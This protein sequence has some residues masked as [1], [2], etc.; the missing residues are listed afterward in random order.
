MEEWR[1]IPGYEG[2]YQASDLGQVRSLDRVEQT[3]D[4]PRR[5]RGR[6]LHPGRRRASGHVAVC[7]GKR[8]TKDVHPLVLRAFVGPPPEGHEALHLN[9]TP[10]DN[11][12]NNLRWGTRGENIAMD[13][14]VKTRVP[15]RGERAP[16]AVLTE[17]MVREARVLRAAGVPYSKLE[18]MLGV[19]LKTISGAVHRRTWGHVA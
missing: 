1:D 4:G 12:L 19:D 7:L 10:T 13:Y 3:I 8:N 6:V 9:H 18:E 17:D 5:Y 2:R 14:E 15:K 16:N 11:R